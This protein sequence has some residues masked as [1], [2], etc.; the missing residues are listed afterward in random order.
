MGGGHPPPPHTHKGCR[1]TKGSSD[2]MGG[3]GGG[4]RG[5]KI[6]FIYYKNKNYLKRETL[7]VDILT[8]N[9]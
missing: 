4:G 3:G 2:E 5:F 6:C 7:P 1:F 8:H 9:Q